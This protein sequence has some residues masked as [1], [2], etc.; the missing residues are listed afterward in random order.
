MPSQCFR[1]ARAL[2]AGTALAG[3]LSLAGCSLL[4]WHHATPAQA[5]APEAS[6]AASAPATANP[7]PSDSATSTG[8]QTVTDTIASPADSNPD[9]ADSTTTDTTTV[10][11]DVGPE[12]KATAPKNYVVRRGDTLWGI[13]NMFLRDPWTWPEIW[14]VNPQIH[15]PHRIYPGDQLRLALGSNGR[16]ALQLVRAPARVAAL[17]GPASETRLQPM[18]RSAALETPIETIPYSMLAAY[19]SRPMV[20]TMQQIRSAGYI[21][22]LP[23]NHDL[24]GRGSEVFI[25]QLAGEVGAR[26]SVL[27][28]DQPLIDP[29]NGNRLGYLA[30]YTGTVQLTRPGRVSEAVMTES[31]RETVPGDVLIPEEHE[32]VADFVPHIPDRP[33]SG[34]IMAVEDLE[35]I[36]TPDRNK[37]LLRLNGVVQMGTLLV[38]TTQVVAINRGS[39]DGLERGHVLTVDQDTQRLPDPCANIAIDSTCAAHPIVTLP[40]DVAGTLLIFRT[41]PHVSYALIL[42]ATVPMAVGNHVHSP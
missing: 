36:W 18:L 9:S 13:A 37:E 14:Y 6:A 22:A 40:T 16:T 20:L 3:L 31:A 17:A 39:S 35:H 21:V 12:L 19:L 27:H 33:V 42:G 2:P 1:A 8:P 15:N 25:K 4:H 29:D 23:Q 41:F 10:V 26:Y 7:E 34:R 28:M 5:P 32:S 11:S 24:A 38:G 30:I